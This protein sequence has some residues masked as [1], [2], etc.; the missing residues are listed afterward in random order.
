MKTTFRRWLLALILLPFVH[1]NAQTD[2]PDAIIVCGNASYTG[3]NATGIGTQEINI[4]NACSSQEH[5]SL[6]LKILIKD[7]G[8][9]GFILN[10][11]SDDLVVDFDFWVYGPNATCG[12]LGTAIRCSTTNPGAAGLDSNVTG[13]NETETDVSEGPN[14]DGN[15]WINWINV[16]DDEIYYLIID[17]PHG[18]ANFSLQWTGTATFHNIPV[19][20]NPDN[21][22]LEIVQCDDDGVH[23][24]S[25]VFDL[26]VF[27]EMFIGV[28]TDVEISYYLDSNGMLTGDNPLDNPAAYANTSSPQTI[29]MRMTNPVTG[30]FDTETMTI[31]LDH[32]FLTGQPQAL[33]LCDTNG[34]G[35]R[36]FDLSQND[37]GIS[38][39]NENTSVTYYASEV[40][41]QNKANPLTVPYQNATA[42]T[43]QTIW[44]RVET[45]GGCF[46]YGITSF[47]I[48]VLPVPEMLRTDDFPPGTPLT[49]IECDDDGVDDNATAFDLTVFEEMLTGTQTDVAL[50]YHI[51]NSDAETGDNALEN[52][53]AYINASN[54]QTIYLRMTNTVT[55]CFA[56]ETITL[57]I[58]HSLPVGNPETLLLCDTDGDGFG[59]FD[60]TQNDE[61]V[62]NGQP[63]TAVTYYVSQA[64]AENKAN[65]LPGI[66]QNQNPNAVQTIWARLDT[67]SGC[68]RHG[69][70]SFNITIYPVPEMLRNDDIPT[71]TPLEI[72]ECD[73]DGTDDGFTA[74]NLRA[75][76]EMLTG[77]Q[78]GVALTYYL[79]YNNALNGVLP[80]ANPQAF[81]NT[82]SPQTVYARMTYTATGCFVT[83]TL[84]I[85][86]DIDM[87]TGIPAPLFL[88]DGAGTGIVQFDLTQN[89][90]AISNG[91]NNTTVTYY[92]SLADAENETNPLPGLYHN[93][94]PYAAQTI[95]A[96]LEGN[97]GCFRYGITSFTIG[98]Y[99]LPEMMRNSGFPVGT[100]LEIVQCDS[101]TIDDVST[102]FD[103]TAFEAML[104]GS[105]TNM[106]FTYHLNADDV[107]T[108]ANPIVFPQA[109]NNTSSPQTVYI[110]MTNTVTGCFATEALTISIDKIIP[111]GIPDNL[112][113]CDDGTGLAVFDLS[114]NNALIKDG[115]PGTVVIYYASEEDAENQQHPL[116]Y[117]YRNQQPYVAETIWARLSGTDGCYRHGL[118]SFTINILPVPEITYTVDVKDFTQDSNCITLSMANIEDYEFSLADG[119]FSDEHIFERLE[120]GIYKIGIR[121][122][123][124]CSE[125]VT[126]VPVLNYPKFFTP[127]GDGINE[128]WNV[129]FIRYFPDAIVNI[130]DRYGKLIKS[131]FGKELGWDGTYNG[132]NLPSTDYWFEV[133]FTSGRKIKG[134]FSMIR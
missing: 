21:I 124:G 71:G 73:D 44:A 70:T 54:P 16:E 30:C 57:S 29:Y 78:S 55:G 45:T 20:Y 87:P 43:T 123:D 85:R 126:F 56:R 39:G 10:P 4:Q 74:F 23:D 120:P 72:V 19:F 65:P 11:E 110:R 125:T 118:A 6:W 40:D 109:F 41:A 50:T 130:F 91:N 8:T 129:F 75:F 116:P 93:Q 26:T 18:Q 28:Q 101:D 5:N 46:R 34:N 132:H 82:S 1:L 104:E 131:Y 47:T 27:E 7:G 68:F 80:I 49:I 17:R 33:S 127:N 114:Q 92:A 61:L 63:N 98:V 36:E 117:F 128:V 51:Q 77:T 64:D 122:K 108:G 15:A 81:V 105:Q 86:T 48:S 58:D 134:H 62:I 25:T 31:K 37:A 88:C 107:L 42:Y 22:P 112:F 66:Y 14:G 67:T 38:N 100:P 133:V 69:I 60:L 24:N 52:P 95:W 3:L 13:M 32:D 35:F 84:S 83:E 9:L 111:T 103:L 121:S 94:T 115:R 89:D 76:E 79:D 59:E 119:D 102:A 99:R 96:W 53:E 106:A 97:D 2:C 90:E 12:N 113:K